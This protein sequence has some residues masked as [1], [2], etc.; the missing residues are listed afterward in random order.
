M[1]DS[2]IFLWPLKNVEDLYDFKIYIIQDKITKNKVR[3]T[4]INTIIVSDMIKS[5]FREHTITIRVMTQLMFT[6]NIL[7]NFSFICF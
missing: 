7:S 1:F 5:D 4:K 6:E 3:V 2:L